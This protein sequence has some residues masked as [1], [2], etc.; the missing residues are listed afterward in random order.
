MFFTTH[1]CSWRL[2]QSTFHSCAAGE[3]GRTENFGDMTDTHYPP[4]DHELIIGIDEVGMGCWAGPAVVAGVVVS[5]DWH[6]PGVKD[7][8]RFSSTKTLTAHDK[9]VRVLHEFI[10]PTAIYST[11]A[12][13]S[14]GQIDEIGV[15]AAWTLG[16]RRVLERCT[17]QFPKALVIIDGERKRGFDASVHFEP[18]ADDRYPAVRAASIVA[19]VSHDS[20]MQKA[21]TIYPGYGFE[22]NNGYGTK[23]HEQ[24][25]WGLGPCPL[26]RRSFLRKWLNRTTHQSSDA[27]HA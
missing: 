4:G 9:R 12:R 27:T 24:G 6:H 8:K 19:K 25:L 3:N 14:A 16:V 2:P 17:M 11:V 21:A 26:H 23:D 1:L 5:A 15:T 18:R 22:T 7:S 10:R 20:L 13:V